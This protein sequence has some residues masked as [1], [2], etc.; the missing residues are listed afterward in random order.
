MVHECTVSVSYRIRIPV[1]DTLFQC[2]DLQLPPDGL[3]SSPPTLEWTAH[4]IINK[5][6]DKQ[7]SGLCC[8]RRAA[9]EFQR[10]SQ[11]RV[12]MTSIARVPQHD[13]R[14]TVKSSDLAS[15][16]HAKLALDAPTRGPSL[17]RFVSSSPI[18]RR[19]RTRDEP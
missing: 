2:V 14:T 13:A 18:R 17:F 5:L 11:A 16:Q 12:P 15:I 4:Q 1:E 10:P 3:P 8:A 6:S 9:A 7:K 19:N